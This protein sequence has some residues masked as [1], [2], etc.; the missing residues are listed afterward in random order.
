VV[1]VDYQPIDL[2]FAN[3]D[4]HTMN[5]SL[6]AGALARIQTRAMNEGDHLCGNELAWYR[7]LSKLNH[8]M[9][10]Y[11]LANNFRGQGLGVTWSSPDKRS[12]FIGSFQEPSE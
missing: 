6:T 4:V 8:S 3:D 7:P 5:A 9:P 1:R 10:A 11:A 2:T 12:A